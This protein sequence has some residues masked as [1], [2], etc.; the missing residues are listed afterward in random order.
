VAAFLRSPGSAHSNWH[1]T[2]R[3]ERL[4]V[5]DSTPPLVPVWLV[6][7]FDHCGLRPGRSQFRLRRK[8][9]NLAM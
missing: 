8:A 5:D 2:R 9:V 7:G 1:W 6:A 3:P 4:T